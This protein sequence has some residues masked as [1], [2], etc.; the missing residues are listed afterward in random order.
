MSQSLVGVRSSILTKYLA[1][2][3][4]A[5]ASGLEYFGR[6]V[7]GKVSVKECT[8]YILYGK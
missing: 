6:F 7:K 4:F 8:Y 1:N 3:S 5:M 2:T